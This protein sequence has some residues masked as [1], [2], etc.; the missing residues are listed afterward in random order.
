MKVWDTELKPLRTLTGHTD[1]VRDA[2]WT[3]DGRFVVTGAE[4][5]RLLVWDGRTF[6]RV[7]EL[8]FGDANE[9]FGQNPA[10]SCV[11]RLA[12][13]RDARW[14]AAAGGKKLDVFD[15]AAGAAVATDKSDTQAAFSPAADV[16]AAGGNTA[17][18]VAYEAARFQPARPDR[19]GRVSAPAA[20]PGRDSRRSRWAT[21]HSGWRSRPTAGPWRAARRTARSKSGR[22]RDAPRRPRRPPAR[23]RDRGRRTTAAQP[24][25]RRPHRR[26][27]RGREPRPRPPGRA[28]R[29]RPPPLPRRDRPHPHPGRDRGVPRRPEPREAPRLDRR[30]AGA[31]GIPRLLARRLR[32]LVER[33]PARA[34]GRRVGG[35]QG[36]PRAPPRRER[37][38][39]PPASCSTRTATTRRAPRPRT[40]SPAASP[41]TTAPRRW[42]R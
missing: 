31:P 36:V 39:G 10:L 40:S 5:G 23:R 35:V 8:A 3:P 25:D 11:H 32:P 41:A 17:R 22:C 33:Q 30:A 14:L 28:A 27:A 9:Q 6:E 12:V 37:R 13:S 16:L 42:T 21:S 4:D 26:R 20:L 24:A 34:P 1:F 7:R 38:L 18:V 19:N 15:L 2:A 29:A